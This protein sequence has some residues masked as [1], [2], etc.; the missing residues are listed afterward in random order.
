MSS[1]SQSTLGLGH[2]TH[3]RRPLGRLTTG[4]FFAVLKLGPVQ[5][6]RDVVRASI[7]Q[8]YR[9]VTEGEQ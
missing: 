6:A 8:T 7:V 1:H 3:G 2:P 9:T 5:T 4:D